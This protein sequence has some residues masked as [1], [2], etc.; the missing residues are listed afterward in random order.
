M[1]KIMGL[2]ITVIL[3]LSLAACAANRTESVNSR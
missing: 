3:I 2:F 1:K